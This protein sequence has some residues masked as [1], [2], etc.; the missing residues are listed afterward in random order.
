MGHVI[1]IEL[2][3]TN[4]CV[5]VL[6]GFSPTVLSNR[7]GYP[8]TPSI[9]AL[10]EDGQRLVGQAAARQ[11]VTNPG[12]TVYGTKQLIG[13]SF[14]SDEVQDAISLL[15]GSFDDADGTVDGTVSIVDFGPN[16]SLFDIDGNGLIDRDD[17]TFYGSVCEADINGDGDANLIDLLLFLDDWFSFDADLDG[18][19]RTD[20]FDLVAYLDLWYVGCG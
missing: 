15:D 19:G 11:A 5:A 3:T 9:L 18:N 16:F 14:D 4:C 1:G 6:S 2:G 10:T 12:Q 20:I 7:Q 17:V 13:R 8:T